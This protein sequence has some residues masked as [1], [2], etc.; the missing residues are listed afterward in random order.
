MASSLHSSIIF[1]NIFNLLQ[2]LNQHTMVYQQLTTY[3][4]TVNTPTSYGSIDDIYMSS[5]LHAISVNSNNTHSVID[6]NYADQYLPHVI[7]I[8]CLPIYTSVGNFTHYT[9]VTMTF[10]TNSNTF[11][12]LEDV[13]LYRGL[14]SGQSK[15][16][17]GSQD[18][19]DNNITMDNYNSSMECECTGEIIQMVPTIHSDIYD[20][21]CSFPHSCI[22]FKLTYTAPILF[23]LQ[24]LN[25]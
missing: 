6:A 13:C 15:I 9:S 17:V 21:V 1:L 2:A 8:E 16:L 14:C 12:T 18:L 11:R 5:L 7:W 10:Q 25:K 3:T 4:S 22:V 23:Y 20:F 19:E 24:C